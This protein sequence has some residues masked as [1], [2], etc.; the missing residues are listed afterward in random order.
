M[1]TN[2]L[3]GT[4]LP[5]ATV[6]DVAAQLQDV[7]NLLMPFGQ[8]LT[9]E[10]RKKF[11]SINEQNKLL[12]NKVRDYHAQQPMLASPDVNWADYEE[13][14]RSRT[15]FE[16]LEQLC[17]S[18]LEICSDPRILHD[19][20]LYQNALVDYDYTKYKA[21]STQSGSAYTTKYEE[22]KQFFPN[23]GGGGSNGG[24]EP[25]PPTPTPNQ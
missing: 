23:T 16:Q 5:P 7:I 25:L 1:P 3:I 12:V 17:N 9:P 2:N 22:L 24:N 18:I 13:N 8:N 14:W 21:N 15:G 10:E 19:H 11:G 6:S 20:H 4:Q